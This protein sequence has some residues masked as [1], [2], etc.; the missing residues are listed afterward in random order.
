ME[1]LNKAKSLWGSVNVKTGELIYEQKCNLKMAKVCAELK[2]AYEKLGRLTYRKLN[3]IKVDDVVFDSVVE[4]I[5]ILKLELDSLRS[6]K[7]NFDSVVFEDGELV[8]GEII[9]ETESED[10]K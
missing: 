1:F 6:G 4:N 9:T 3:G 2:K 10:E 7:Y 5:E 8:E